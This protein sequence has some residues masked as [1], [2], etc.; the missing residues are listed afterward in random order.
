MI[1]TTEKPIFAATR[2]IDFDRLRDVSCD[3]QEMMLEIVALYFEQAKQ[4]TTELEE[5]AAAGDAKVI[6]ELAH[7]F[8]GGSSTCGMMI[9]VSP[10]K[11]LEE[12]GKNRNLTRAGE[13]VAQIRR[14]VEKMRLEWLSYEKQSI[15]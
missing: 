3:D 4:W 11:E 10:L 12:A 15:R 8:K 2:S 9:V 13:L 5:A 7:K 1:G 6:Y 14:G